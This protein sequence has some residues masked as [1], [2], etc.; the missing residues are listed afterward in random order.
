MSRCVTETREEAHYPH[1]NLDALVV[2]VRSSC[3]HLAF[4]RH[5]M[6]RYTFTYEFAGKRRT[7]Q[8]GP[9][10]DDVFVEPGEAVRV[11]DVSPDLN[12]VDWDFRWAACTGDRNKSAQE[13][14]CY[15]AVP[16]Q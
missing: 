7:E 9:A 2:S 8:G 1:N 12:Y 3:S 11:H 4:V 6:G 16:Q 5:C 13:H 15:F 10:C 14:P